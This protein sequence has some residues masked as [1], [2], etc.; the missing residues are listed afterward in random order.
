MDYVKDC[1]TTSIRDTSKLCSGLYITYV[2]K[3]N[4]TTVTM[5]CT[6]TDMVITN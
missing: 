2:F 5:Q 1:I 6:P 3:L 4:V